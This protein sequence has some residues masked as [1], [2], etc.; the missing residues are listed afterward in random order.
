MS[1]NGVYQ[2]LAARFDKHQT[3]KQAGTD[4]TYLTGEQVVSRLNEVL[5]VTGWS[6]RVVREGVTDTEAWV[7]GE[8]TSTI[9]GVMVTRQQYGNQEL[10]RGQRATSDL[11]KSACTDAVKK[12]ATTI[13]IGLY[14]YDQDERR[15][16]EA[17]MRQASR[18][19]KP[20]VPSQQVG[21]AATVTG[22][23]AVT[24]TTETVKERWARLVKEA[25]AVNLPTLKQVKAIDPN[26]VTEAQL[27]RYADRLDN[28]LENRDA[29]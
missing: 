24:P 21:A 8:L 25:E 14:L 3:R 23:P 26:A 5:G 18:T 4:L 19:P 7:L 20:A 28:R 29:A 22:A 12:A 11:F 9:D 17:E 6:F 1:D 27:T 16:V 10:M 2:K 15:E 13:G